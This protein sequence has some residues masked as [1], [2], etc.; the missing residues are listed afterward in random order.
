M[1]GTSRP[2]LE[3]YGWDTR[4][5]A[6]FATHA[7]SG[8]VPGRVTSAA[9]DTI[10]ARTE[11]GDT[12]VVVQRGFRREAASSADYPAVGDWLALEPVADGQAALRAVLSRTSRFA[13]GE[14]RGGGEVHQQM[15]AAHVDTV[16]IVAA[17]DNDLNLRRLE[18]TLAL[19]WASG[20]DPVLLLNKA[21]LCDDVVARL[22]EVREIASGAPVLVASALRAEGLE[23]LDAWMGPGRTVV[24]LGSSGVGKSTITNQLLG[25]ERQAV[26]DVREDDARGRHTTTARELFQL[27]GGG[28]LIDTPGMRSM[29]LWD[30]DDGLD[31]TFTDIEA[32]AADCRFTDC[33]HE[34]E[35]GCA[36]LAAIERGDL[37]A[38]RLRARRKL[39]R[40][41]GVVTLQNDARAR[42]AESRRW[43]RITR[44]AARHA[45]AKR[46]GWGHG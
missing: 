23:A 15:V 13:R 44:E 40:E 26:R 35:P 43:G 11:T 7:A 38:D 19:A 24:L 17:L 36:V 31:R 29:G 45:D 3:A 28:L 12:G 5:E 18:R 37:A 10:R 27:P 6:A 33:T 22:G 30:A 4:R 21:D 42:H 8:F 2:V 39:Q 20:A 1:G 9:R 16:I 14:E 34:V 32:F 41:L 25:E 46:R